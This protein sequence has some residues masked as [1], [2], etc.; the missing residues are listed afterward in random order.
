ME[1]TSSAAMIQMF[2]AKPNPDLKG[3]KLGKL[4]SFHANPGV[5]SKQEIPPPQRFRANPA[6]PVWEGDESRV[7]L[8][9]PDTFRAILNALRPEQPA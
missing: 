2:R 7:C 5:L 4:R 8:L 1:V 6:S 3:L 9:W